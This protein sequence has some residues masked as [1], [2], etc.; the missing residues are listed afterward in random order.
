[1][2]LFVFFMSFLSRFVIHIIFNFNVFKLHIYVKFSG[3]ILK[4][5]LS[6]I[7]TSRS[8]LRFVNIVILFYKYL[9]CKFW[10]IAYLNDPWEILCNICVYIYQCRVI[11]FALRHCGGHNV[12]FYTWFY[13]YFPPYL[14]V[15]SL[16]V[17]C[18][19]INYK[20]VLFFYLHFCHLI[21]NYFCSYIRGNSPFLTY[22]VN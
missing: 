14:L 9:Y 15:K 2:G 18:L 20:F 3:F 6:L 17:T 11:V 22:S 12:I 13:F 10:C 5:S 1:M 19:L 16:T 21:S 4:Y 8:V 7:I